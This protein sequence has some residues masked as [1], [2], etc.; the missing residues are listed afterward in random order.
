IIRT[1]R[2]QRLL[3]ATGTEPP[4]LPALLGIYIRGWFANAVTVAQLG[5]VFR[6][7]LVQRAA[8]I[9]RA[10]TLGAIV[11]ERLRDLAARAALL[12]G[13]PLLAFPGQAPRGLWA[14]CASVLI[15]AVV[16]AGLVATASRRRCARRLPARLREGIEALTEAFRRSLGALP[17]A[18]GL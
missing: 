17:A 14:A 9:P 6:A 4:T 12:A 7:N 11:A 2:W 18:V 5:D 16:V 10:T 3:A 15:G 8:G 13:A 1:V